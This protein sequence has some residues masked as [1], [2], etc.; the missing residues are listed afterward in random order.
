MGKDIDFKVYYAKGAC[1][2]YETWEG[3]YETWGDTPIFEV[4]A[5]VQKDRDH[6]R[7]VVSSGDYYVWTDDLMWVSC[8][9]ETRDMYMARKGKE[10]RYLI[11][12]MVGH[13][14]WNRVM[15]L[16]R[17]D[18]DF[19]PQTGLHMYEKRAGIN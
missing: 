15:E 19:L 6:G 10:K 7:K 1:H 17:T 4:L 2:G 3:T 11:G 18:P 5:I 16:A 9:K 14:E 13:E 12:S 8:D